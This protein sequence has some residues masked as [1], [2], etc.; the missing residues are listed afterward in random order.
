MAILPKCN[1]CGRKGG[2]A[3]KDTDGDCLRCKLV[4]QTLKKIEE[5]NKPKE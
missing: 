2:Y 3:L 1:A 4:K 5:T